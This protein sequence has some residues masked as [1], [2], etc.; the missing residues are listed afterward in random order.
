MPIINEDQTTNRSL[1]LTSS[2][3]SV[4]QPFIGLESNQLESYSVGFWIKPLSNE[5]GVLFSRYSDRHQDIFFDN[6]QVRYQEY[7]TSNGD[8]EDFIN[9]KET[10]L[11]WNHITMTVSDSVK[12][13][14]NGVLSGTYLSTFN[15][16]D[17]LNDLIFGANSDKVSESFDGLMDEIVVYI[18]N[19]FSKLSVQ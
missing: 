8:A 10:P 6:N 4:D 17:P 7:A 18:S 1:D 9:L 2:F 3:G 14:V 13:Y 12:F 19:I 5:P 15:H 11:E 16:E